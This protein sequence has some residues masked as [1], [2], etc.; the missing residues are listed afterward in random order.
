MTARMNPDVMEDDAAA[1]VGP[2]LAAALRDRFEQLRGKQRAAGLEEEDA[3]ELIYRS[4][5]DIMRASVPTH[6]GRAVET[7]SW[8]RRPDRFVAQAPRRQRSQPAHRPRQHRRHRRRRRQR[9]RLAEVDLRYRHTA[10]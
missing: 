7:T 6:K 10:S 8:D 3:V 9:R 1:I 2:E 4:L 5:S